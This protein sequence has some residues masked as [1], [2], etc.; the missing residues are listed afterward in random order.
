MTETHRAEEVLAAERPRL[1]GLAYR[2]TGSRADAE[3]IVQE[4]WFRAERADWS[5]IRSPQGWLTT[6]VS[7]IA[8]DTLKSATRQREEYVGPWLPEPV[9]TSFNAGRAEVRDDSDPARLAELAESVTLGFLRLLENLTPLE[10]VVFILAD[11]FD[12]PYQEIGAVVGR[13]AQ[14]C[15]QTATRAR[16]HVRARQRGHDPPADAQRVAKELMVAIA[17]GEIGQVVSLLADDVVLVSDGG[18]KR[19]A[20]RRP[21]LGPERVARLLVNLS[22]RA[23]DTQGQTYMTVINGE[24]GAVLWDRGELYGVATVHVH[25]GRVVELHFVVNPDKL[26]GLETVASVL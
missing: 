9:V 11:V 5:A 17:G 7:R 12:T 21:V 20:A 25:Q 6:V 14:A 26:S 2:I 19:H 1:V 10:R 8:L 3:D 13:S 24:P 18:S 22:R 15:R 4:A 23:A 16:R